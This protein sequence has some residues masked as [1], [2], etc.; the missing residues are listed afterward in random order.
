MKLHESV[1]PRMHICR[2]GNLKTYT[3]KPGKTL[4]YRHILHASLVIV[5]HYIRLEIGNLQTSSF[6]PY[7]G[8]HLYGACT[9]IIVYY[10]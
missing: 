3:Q 1:I 2:H 9:V 8:I 10:T 4:D 5:C 6:G 7:I